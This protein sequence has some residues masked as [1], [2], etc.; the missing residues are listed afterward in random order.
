MSKGRSPHQRL[1]VRERAVFPQE[2]VIISFLVCLVFSFSLAFLPLFFCSFC[3]WMMISLEREESV[4]TICHSSHFLSL[5]HAR[6]S[7]S[8][9]WQCNQ[10]LNVLRSFPVCSPPSQ[11][12]PRN[13]NGK[14]GVVLDNAFHQC[15]TTGSA[16]WG[17]LIGYTRKDCSAS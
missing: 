5:F 17:N 16:D 11:C 4:G 2:L 14:L 7:V 13:V 8:H 12:P 10:P 1:Q 3:P 6:T 9:T 15:L